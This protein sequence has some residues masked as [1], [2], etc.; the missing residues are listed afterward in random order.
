MAALVEVFDAVMDSRAI[1]DAFRGF[2]TLQAAAASLAHVIADAEGG[3]VDAMNIYK[4]YREM[5]TAHRLGSHI[6]DSA[7]SP[8]DRKRR[9]T[10]DG[11]SDDVVKRLRFPVA[12]SR[13]RRHG[14]VD[15]AYTPIVTC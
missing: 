6:H 11:E 14:M 4:G 12:H 1:L 7:Q 15:L 5:K 9:R 13:S 10:D 8:V 2:P 3:V